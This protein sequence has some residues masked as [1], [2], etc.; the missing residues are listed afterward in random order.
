MYPFGEKE[1]SINKSQE[2][3]GRGSMSVI[4]PALN[5]KRR[6]GQNINSTEFQN[7][8]VKKLVFML[9]IRVFS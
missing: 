7:P 8:G 5:S 9:T 2:A 6:V 3:L 4:E 1:G